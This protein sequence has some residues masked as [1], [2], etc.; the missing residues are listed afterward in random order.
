MYLPDGH[1]RCL[2]R[3]ADLET[4]L[5]VRLAHLK[6]FPDD[7][8]RKIVER[9]AVELHH[10]LQLVKSAFEC[11]DV[12]DL[13]WENEPIARTLPAGDGGFLPPAPG[14]SFNAWN[15]PSGT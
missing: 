15:N 10:Q 13:S 5:R 2:C 6:T 4:A 9:H 3:V 12:L 11:T 14:R 7:P 1:L 8:R